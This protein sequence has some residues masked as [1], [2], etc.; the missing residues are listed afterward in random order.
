MT[1]IDDELHW[2]DLTLCH[3]TLASGH[4]SQGERVRFIM[5]EKLQKE[6][7]ATFFLCPFSQYCSS[8]KV[9]LDHQHEHL[10][11]G[12]AEF[13]AQVGCMI[14]ER[15]LLANLSLKENLLLPFLYANQRKSL[16]QAEKNLHQVAHFLGIEDQLNEKA[17]NR[18]IYMHGLMSLGH[19]LLKKTSI[20][21][22]QDLYLGMQA[23]YATKFHRKVLKTLKILNPGVLYL[24]SSKSNQSE[25]SFDRSY[26]LT[27]DMDVN[28]ERS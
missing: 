12:S 27:C 24:T 6:L 11:S 13:C 10:S 16:Q 23:E 21:I 8:P 5:H 19:C 20:V 17:G 26:H 3:Q 18:P 4:I 22:A 15:G 28:M 25:L 1:A 14:R 7:L 9:W 2:H